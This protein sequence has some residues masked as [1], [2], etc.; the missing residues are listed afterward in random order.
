MLNSDDLAQLMKERL[1][2]LFQAAQK[3]PL[4]QAGQEDREL[5]FKAIAEAVVQHVHDKGEINGDV[6]VLGNNVITSG[7]IK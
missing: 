5:L 4:P 1:D 6:L 3:G 2:V 7:V